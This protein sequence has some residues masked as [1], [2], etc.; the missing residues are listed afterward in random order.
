[1]CHAL[2]RHAAIVYLAFYGDIECPPRTGDGLVSSDLLSMPLRLL[3]R[4]A[5]LLLNIAEHVD[6]RQAERLL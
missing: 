6:E 2:L 1:M 3:R 4:L 5:F